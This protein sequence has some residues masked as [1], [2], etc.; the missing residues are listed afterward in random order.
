MEKQSSPRQ[1]DH[2]RERKIYVPF[3]YSALHTESVLD[4]WMHKYET[5]SFPSCCMLKFSI[6]YLR[7]RQV[8]EP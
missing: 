2:A 5:Q 1:A 7:T 3:K 4:I 6:V 8:T